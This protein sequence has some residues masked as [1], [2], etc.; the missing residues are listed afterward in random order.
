MVSHK[1][2]SIKYHG[3]MAANYEAKR[4][5]QLR[6]HLENIAVRNMLEGTPRKAKLLDAPVGQGRFLQLYH[7]LELDVLGVDMSR[8]M[9]AQA[10]VTGMATLCQGDVTNLAFL[11]DD[12][13]HTAVCVRFLDLIPE[14]TMQSA[15]RELCR[16]TNNAIVL[17]IRLG[18]EYLPK[19]NTATHDHDRFL[20]LIQEMNWQIIKDVPI[21]N[22]GWHVFKLSCDKP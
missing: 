15:M 6:W 3:R 9:M 16:V 22:K 14:E 12:Q 8:D 13:F 21:F 19:V 10:K 2:T 17:T 20:S 5:K 18:P 7:D 11:A 1:H 4:S